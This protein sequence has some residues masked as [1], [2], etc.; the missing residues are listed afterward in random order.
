MTKTRI[1][2]TI[3]PVLL[4]RLDSHINGKL[5][6]SRSEV[7]EIL[8]KKQLRSERTAVILAGGSIEHLSVPGTNTIR[9]LV[10]I[11]SLTLIEQILHQV[12]SAGHTRILI[13][14]QKVTLDLIYGKIFSN[15]TLAEKL[16]FIEESQSL[17]TAR[18][19]ENVKERV[20]TNFL[21]VPCDTY[22]DFNIEDLYQ[23]HTQQNA[24]ATFAIYSRTLFDSKYKGVVEL[25]GFRIISHDEQPD[26]PKSHLI[27]TMIVV[28][29][30]KIF[31][32]IP[33]GEMVWRLEQE[34]INRLIV[35]K[36]A[37]GYPIAG[38]WF[39]IHSIED[40]DQLKKHLI[41]KE[42]RL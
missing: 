39:N 16:E 24:L 34:V 12:I 10:T 9:P 13:V 15:R 33:A 27:K 31:E 11:N 42:T 23:F 2:I 6:R 38:N 21:V 25:D 40:L 41:D 35:D 8:L 32:Y 28:L 30:D 37:F 20:S 7:I 29:S 3:D 22:F 4:D 36:K 5:V 1:T 19:L 26:Q 14:G 17:G 18:T